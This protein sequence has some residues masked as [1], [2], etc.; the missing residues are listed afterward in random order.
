MFFSKNLKKICFVFSFLLFLQLS[1]SSQTLGNLS[2][3]RI[4]ELTDDQIKTFILEADRMGLK[5]SDIESIGLQNGLSQPELIKLKD[6]I[7]AGRKILNTPNAQALLNNK[8]INENR[9]Q[10]SVKRVEQNPAKDIYTPFKS[11]TSSNFGFDVF[12]NPKITFEPNLRIPTPK[13]YQLAA[14]DELNIDVSGYSEANYKLK[15]SP[16]GSIRIPLVGPIHVNGLTIEQASRIIEKKLANTLYYNIKTGNTFVDVSLGNIR[17]IKVTIIGEAT[18]PGTYTLPSLATAFNALY[19]CGGAN[20]NGTLRNI[21]IIRNSSIIATMDVYQYL[22]NGNRKQDIRL[23]DDDVIKINTYTTRIELKGEVKKPGLYDIIKGETLSQVIQY[24]G[25][26]TDNAYTSKITVFSNSNRDRQISN[27]NEA[28]IAKLVP[29]RGDNFIVGKINNRFSNRIDI[30]GAV[31]RPGVYELRDN[32]TLL[33]LIKEADGLREDAFISRGSIHRLKDDL[34]PE[35]ISFDLEKIQK[36]ELKDIPLKKEDRINIFSKFDLKEG[37]YVKI[38][39]EVANPGVYLYEE[40]LTSEDLIMMAGGF[41]ES[42]SKKRIEI[43]RRVKDSVNVITTETSNV[44]TAL[45]YQ[46]DVSSDLRENADS[47]KFYLQPFDEIS[48]Y[49]SPG[50]FEQK[51]VVIEGEIIYSGKYSLQA[52]NDRISDL[53][54]RSGGLTN[55]A[56]IKGAV[57]VRARRLSKTEQTNLAQGVSNLIKSNYA[58]GTPEALLQ[59]EL[60]KTINKSSEIIGIDLEKILDEPKSDYDLLLND[61]DTLRIPKMLQTVR[62]NGEV[63]YPTLVRYSKELGFKDYIS[64]AGGYS[65]RSSRKKSYAVYPNGSVRGTKSF[66]FFKNYPR[67]TPGTEIYVPVKRERERLR[68]GEIISIGATLTTLL[69]VAYSIIK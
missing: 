61:G 13:N 9:Q 56:Y 2:N 6:R 38:E 26:F 64:G 44:K 10:D 63:L 32:M 67:I 57:L 41:M 1:G 8:P 21:Q 7:Q 4:E 40:G 23:M 53:I 55:E 5:D 27:I 16:E 14:D 69:L 15:V 24:A 49:K 47:S 66:L 29:K 50:Y 17:S 3:V 65:D 30:K 20:Y 51:N 19:A 28:E 62:V 12:N 42:A 11:L 68:T 31:Y 54:S 58:S 35:I 22:V 37:Y 33:D 60:S 34:S 36:G 43:S 59:F 25:G 45:I 48:I 52:K 39:G 46:K 18:V